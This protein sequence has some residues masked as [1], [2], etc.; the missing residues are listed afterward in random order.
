MK[1]NHY[2]CAV[3]GDWH[4]AFVTAACLS[5]L[6]HKTLLVNPNKNYSW[7][8]FPELKLHE[9]GLP[10]MISHSRQAGLLDS[11]NGISNAWT[12]DKIWL[13]IDTPV[14]DRDEAN[15]APLR[16]VAKKVSEEFKTFKGPFIMSSQIPLGFSA[17]VEKESG[18]DVVYIPENLR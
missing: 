3:I 18:L 11:A 15:L 5:S 4:L 13:A 2:S 8:S 6:G 7:D 9:P 12:A 17:E 1:S 14:N 10:E 16:E